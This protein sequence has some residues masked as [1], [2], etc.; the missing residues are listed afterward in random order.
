MSAIEQTIVDTDVNG[1][2]EWV[3]PNPTLSTPIVVATA[4]D[5]QGG[6]YTAKDIIGVFVT[7]KERTPTSVKG[8]AWTLTNVAGVGLMRHASQVEV[9][10]VAVY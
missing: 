5:E 6:L 3:L 10:L 1:Q 7:I 4:H 2:F 8:E 9:A